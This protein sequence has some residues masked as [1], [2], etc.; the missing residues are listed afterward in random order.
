MNWIPFVQLNLR[1]NA[2][3]FLQKARNSCCWHKYARKTF[4][5]PLSFLIRFAAEIRH[6][7]FNYVSLYSI[8]PEM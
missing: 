2:E 4:V 8:N 3:I 1:F 7:L 5:E 6:S